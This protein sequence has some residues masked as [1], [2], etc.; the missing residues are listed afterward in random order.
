MGV[1]VV[2]SNARSVTALNKR[3]ESGSG[4]LMLFHADWC[5]HCHALR[6]EWTRLK[7]MLAGFA[8]SVNELEHGAIA[9]IN[10]NNLA[11][12]CNVFGYPTIMFFKDNN[13]VQYSGARTA[14]AIRDWLM[15]LGVS[16]APPKA[17]PPPAK[18]ARK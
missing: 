11:P 5:G 12:Y 9:F 4:N 14:E 7:E 1:H 17:R 18:R 2:A 8:V 16:P 6:P 3:V 13:R 10:K 15:S